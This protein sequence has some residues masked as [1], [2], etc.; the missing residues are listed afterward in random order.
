MPESQR[1]ATTVAGPSEGA[2]LPTGRA[3]QLFSKLR[4]GAKFI[5]WEL[6]QHAAS[7]VHDGESDSDEDGPPLLLPTRARTETA[8]MAHVARASL[9]RYNSLRKE[10]SLRA[11]GGASAGLGL[12]PRSSVT[13]AASPAK[14]GDVVKIRETRPLS[15]L[16]RWELVEVVR[17]AA[18][19]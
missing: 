17:A 1:M 18:T 2:T 12:S 10:G 6:Q 14:T 5:K 3:K 19:A 7:V 15:K 11:R 13:D 8:S 9:L 16:K 4:L